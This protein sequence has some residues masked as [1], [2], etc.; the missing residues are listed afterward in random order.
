MPKQYNSIYT[1]RRKNKKIIVYVDIYILSYWKK[2]FSIIIIKSI[3][4]VKIDQFI[5]LVL[6]SL[7]RI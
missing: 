2:L 7:R 3:Q 4:T 1:I 6:S 5:L